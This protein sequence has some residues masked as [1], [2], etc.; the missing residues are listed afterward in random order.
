RRAG[1]ADR[2]QPRV[3]AEVRLPLRRLRQRAA[4]ERDRADH[5]RA[6]RAH[7]RGGAGDRA[8]RARRD[9]R[10]PLAAVAGDELTLLGLSDYWW[11]WGD[12]LIRWLHVIAAIAWVG[13]S[14]Y[15][16]AL[17]NH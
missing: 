5:P 4:E 3:R 16:I 6:D 15:F 9:R 13:A 10:R 17:D 12:L 11:G 1:G 2:A 8:R 14:F 7:A